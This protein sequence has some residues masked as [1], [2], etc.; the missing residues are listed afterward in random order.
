MEN[1]YQLEEIENGYKLSFGVDFEMHLLQFLL[2]NATQSQ[3]YDVAMILPAEDDYTLVKMGIGK[4]ISEEQ[5]QIIDE[6]TK[7]RIN[8]LFVEFYGRPLDFDKDSTISMENYQS[9]LSDIFLNILDADN[10]EY[11]IDEVEHEIYHTEITFYEM[12]EFLSYFLYAW[13]DD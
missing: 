3:E 8:K 4:V 10:D 9:Y 6:F 12:P 7:R 2:E 13:L 1:I 11:D 5:F